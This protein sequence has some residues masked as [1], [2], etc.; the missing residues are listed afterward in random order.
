[1]SW[2]SDGL[3]SI[4]SRCLKNVKIFGSLGR[5]DVKKIDKDKCEAESPTRTVI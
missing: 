1:M 4:D 3:M 5:V 2:I